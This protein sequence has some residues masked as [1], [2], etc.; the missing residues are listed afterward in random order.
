MIEDISKSIKANMYER[1][2][3]PL[4]GAFAI[5]WAIWNYK[6]ILAILS[7]MTVKEKVSYIENEIYAV[8]CKF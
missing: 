8:N 1:A 3:S 7:S 4:F 5:S 2:T 6:T